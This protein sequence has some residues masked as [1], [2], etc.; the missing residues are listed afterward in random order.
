MAKTPADTAKRRPQTFGIGAVAKIT[1]LSDHTI[2]VWERRYQAVVAERA[3]NGRRVYSALDVEK[4]SVLKAL[5]DQGHSIGSI[6]NDSLGDLAARVDASRQLSATNAPETVNV[7]VLGDFLPGKL[8]AHKKSLSPL[9]LVAADTSAE[10][11]TADVRQQPVDVLV[12]ELPILSGETLGR[13]Q[14]LVAASGARHGVCIYSF[15]KSADCE[16]LQDAGILVLRA[17]VSV[18]EVRA[19]AQRVSRRQKDSSPISASA[20][21]QAVQL[22]WDSD[23]YIAPRRF[24]QS[25]LAKLA[26]VSSGIECECPQHLAQLVGDL[27]AFEVYSSQCANRNDDDAELHRFLHRTTAAARAMIEESLQRVAQAEG[28]EY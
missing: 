28:I 25:Q 26:S 7:A 18:E 15:G 27:S 19:A 23:S 16:A 17:P 4:L 24:S 2:R 22:G 8:A 21:Y 13:I 6:A 14:N 10:R 11:F 9:R 20:D 5:T 12:L 3:T 1:G